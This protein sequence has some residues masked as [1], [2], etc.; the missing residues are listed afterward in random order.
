MCAN[1]GQRRRQRA[2]SSSNET[3]IV[4]RRPHARV[5]MIDD[6]KLATRIHHQ[7]G[8]VIVA[9]TQHARTCRQFGGDVVQF[10]S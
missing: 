6:A 7:I 1:L 8:R 4:T 9:M 3:K 5:L 10:C 2:R